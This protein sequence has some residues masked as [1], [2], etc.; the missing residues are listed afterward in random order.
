MVTS[1]G[2]KG[3]EV[4]AGIPSL[5]FTT[6]IRSSA[7]LGRPEELFAL[8]GDL[9]RNGYQYV[10]VISAASSGCRDIFYMRSGVA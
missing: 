8:T 1:N 5:G 10:L 4:E 7:R 3:G 9:L 6:C 2:I